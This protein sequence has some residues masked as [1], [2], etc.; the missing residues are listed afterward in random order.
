MRFWI[1]S[2]HTTEDFR[3]ETNS[4]EVA[5]LMQMCGFYVVDSWRSRSCWT[6]FASYGRLPVNSS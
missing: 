6:V 4:I 5:T 2:M 1:T 3:H